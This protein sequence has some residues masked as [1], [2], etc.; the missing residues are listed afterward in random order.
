MK[1]VACKLC[2][3]PFVCD[4]GRW[5]TTCTCAKDRSEELKAAQEKADRTCAN[6][7][8]P[9]VDAATALA[10]LKWHMAEDAPPNVGGSYARSWHDS[11]ACCAM[12]EGVSHEV[13]NKIAARFMKMAF[14]VMTR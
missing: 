9:I 3:K 13:A 1:Q 10:S 6:C 14:D 12:D 2:D 11:L 5:F 4:N 7:T 8:P